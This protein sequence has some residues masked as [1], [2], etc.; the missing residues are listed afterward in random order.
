M[1]KLARELY[2]LHKVDII[3]K[4]LYSGD[5]LVDIKLRKGTLNI[6]KLSR[7]KWSWSIK[8]MSCEQLTVLID[9]HSYCGHLSQRE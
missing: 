8:L 2:S 6:G 3:H 5:V 9:I 4:D 1:W 7:R